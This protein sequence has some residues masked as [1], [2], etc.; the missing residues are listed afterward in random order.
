V[1]KKVG[2]GT[3]LKTDDVKKVGVATVLKNQS[4][5]KQREP[6]YLP[7][8]NDKEHCFMQVKRKNARFCAT[9]KRIIWGKCR[10]MVQTPT[11]RW[12]DR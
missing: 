10:W 12:E 2:L 4:V 7:C 3:S 1:E 6:Y 9:W 8:G 5:E 11:C